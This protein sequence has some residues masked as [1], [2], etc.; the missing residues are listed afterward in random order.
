MGTLSSPSSSV[1]SSLSFFTME[2]GAGTALGENN[3]I[4]GLTYGRVSDTGSSS[5]DVNNLTPAG[6]VG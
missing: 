2:R 4:S 3:L 5:I 1:S 6:L